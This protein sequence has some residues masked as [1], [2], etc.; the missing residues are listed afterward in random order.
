MLPMRE[1][2]LRF[3]RSLFLPVFLVFGS[4]CTAPEPTPP[5]N[6]LL[7]SIDTLRADRLGSYGFDA[8]T[9]PALDQLAA[10]GVRFANAISPSNWTLPAHIS[11]FT[12]Q[13]VGS[14]GIVD[15]RTS[16]SA[17]AL[18]LTE[19]LA[20]QGYQTAAFAS[21]VYLNPK[22]GFEQGFEEYYLQLDPDRIS[23]ADG[24]GAFD[25]RRVVDAAEHWL[26]ST[27]ASP[28]FLFV[29]LFDPHLGYTP[30]PPY[31][32]MYTGEYSGP[33][34]GTYETAKTRILGMNESVPPLDPADRQHL[35]GLYQG[36]VRFVDDQVQRLVQAFEA[37]S[38][39]SGSLIV[40]VADHGEEIGDHGSLEGHGW[41]LYEE[42]VRVPMI[43]RFP[44]GAHQG[45]VIEQPVGLIDVAPTL[46]DFLG[47]RSAP[48][49]QGQSLLPL[50]L[51][52]EASPAPRLIFSDSGGRLGIFKRSV[53]GPR[54]KLIET[55]DT[56]QNLFGVPI[57]AGYELYD[58]HAD[59]GERQN[60]FRPDHPA[61][62]HL[63]RALEQQLVRDS[64]LRGQ[65]ETGA[66]E[67]SEEERKMLESLGYIQ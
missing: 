13:S 61:A 48:Q 55:R 49:F 46:L 16:L 10:N 64:S 7:I 20:D 26:Y 58:L 50:I 1:S 24:G 15:D 4:G 60:L 56:G 53:R 11:L 40:V 52:E 51:G 12:S 44:G 5:P 57:Q 36:E 66:V 39:E 33:L 30:P 8:P 21:W 17:E 67:L 22:F 34:D 29:H 28:L 23:L 25:A 27:D 31:D 62:R 3:L 59:P 37:R 43:W 45:R 54:F 9:S 63:L 18:T 2:P 42:V 32:Q 47:V 6:I 41:T 19:V 14:H 35:D 38:P 65:V